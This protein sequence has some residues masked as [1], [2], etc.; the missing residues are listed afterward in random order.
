MDGICLGGKRGGEN[1]SIGVHLGVGMWKWRGRGFVLTGPPEVPTQ[2]IMLSKS[3]CYY[4]T[5]YVEFMLLH[6]VRV[7]S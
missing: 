1:C 4:F 6:I 5:A 2:H 3:L 7:K